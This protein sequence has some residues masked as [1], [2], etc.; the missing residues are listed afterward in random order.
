MA[1][2][3]LIILV[4][5]LSI[6]GAVLFLAMALKVDHDAGNHPGYHNHEDDEQ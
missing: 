2:D 3:L 4:A 1:H 6:A 5:F